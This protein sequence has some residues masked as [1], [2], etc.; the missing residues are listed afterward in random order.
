MNQFI[1]GMILKYPYYSVYDD[2]TGENIFFNSFCSENPNKNI[3]DLK[4]V[5][6]CFE[7]EFSVF[8]IENNILLYHY[9]DDSLWTEINYS[10]ES[11]C[12]YDCVL[13]SLESLSILPVNII[14][15]ILFGVERM[16][17]LQEIHVSINDDCQVETTINSLYKINI[18]NQDKICIQKNNKIIF[19]YEDLDCC[20]TSTN[21]EL[22]LYVY[23]SN[24]IIYYGKGDN[25]GCIVIKNLFF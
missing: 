5:K 16:K 1:E 24:L 4:F 22:S 9:C 15:Q 12:G 25:G 11:I 18:Y 2:D 8:M 23:R 14:T 10:C 3:D 7:E 6:I 13:Y 17:D 19:E 21:E 20:Y